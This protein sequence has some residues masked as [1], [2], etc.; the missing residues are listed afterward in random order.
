MV[1][2]CADPQSEVSQPGDP[3]ARDANGKVIGRI[4]RT[5]A[6]MHQAQVA[7]DVD[8]ELVPV[9]VRPDSF[10]HATGGQI[11]FTEANCM[12]QA[13]IGADGQQDTLGPPAAVAGERQTLYIGDRP[14]RSLRQL[15]SLLR[16]AD[17]EPFEVEAFTF[18]AREA[19]QLRD[20]FVPPYRFDNP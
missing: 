7:I 17:C 4:A 9:L 18:E 2:G 10:T 1:A 19:M 13:L 20:H 3:V 12:G 11:Y 16:G 15:G 5:Y 14:T 6:S 8:G